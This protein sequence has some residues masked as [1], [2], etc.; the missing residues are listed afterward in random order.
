MFSQFSVTSGWRNSWAEG[1]IFVRSKNVNFSSTTSHFLNLCKLLASTTS[2]SEEFHSVTISYIKNRAT[3]GFLLNLLFG[4]FSWSPSYL[5]IPLNKLTLWYP[6]RG[7]D[8]K[9]KSK[10]GIEHPSLFLLLRTCCWKKQTL[11]EN[12]TYNRGWKNWLIFPSL[13]G[14]CRSLCTENINGGQFPN[15]LLGQAW[16]GAQVPACASRAF[17]GALAQ[18]ASAWCSALQLRKRLFVFSPF[19]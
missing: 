19:Y 9:K 7:R 14:I 18:P 13:E 10:K 15:R 3:L 5:P 12:I 6:Q 1:V 11:N 17:P 16:Q 8:S 2:C 4:F